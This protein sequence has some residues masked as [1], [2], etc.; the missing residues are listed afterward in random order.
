M[1]HSRLSTIVI[2]CHSDHL[3]AATAF[4]SQA[5]GKSIASPDQDGDGGE[6][7]QGVGDDIE[8]R[9]DLRRGGG[10]LV[11][12]GADREPATQGDAGLAGDRGVVDTG[13]RVE[14]D[15]G[16]HVG[17]AQQHCLGGG[18]VEQDQPD[19]GVGRGE[20]RHPDHPFRGGPG[21]GEHPHRVDLARREPRQ[22]HRHGGGSGVGHHDHRARRRRR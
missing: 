14:G 19:A 21:R 10:R 1:H 11:G 22:C 17:F 9:A 3:D 7:E 12:L 6:P 15:R 18:G 5:L 16:E 2:D 20:R 13:L 4:W 8:K